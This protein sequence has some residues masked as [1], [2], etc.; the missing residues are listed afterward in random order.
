[1]SS[2][3]TNLLSGFHW[4][5]AVA[6]LFDVKIYVAIYHFDHLLVF[7]EIDHP[8]IGVWKSDVESHFEPLI[9]LRCECT[10]CVQCTL[11]KALQV[12]GLDSQFDF[13]VAVHNAPW[14]DDLEDTNLGLRHHRRARTPVQPMPPAADLL[15]VQPEPQRV[16]RVDVDLLHRNMKILEDMGMCYRYGPELCSFML[17]RNQNILENAIAGLMEWEKGEGAR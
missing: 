1:M 5:R 4:L 14:M 2:V 11:P 3:F 16:H 8:S 9:P 10:W 13:D 12:I 6:H 15:A 17:R 7:G